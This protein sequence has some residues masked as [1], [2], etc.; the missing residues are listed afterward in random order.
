MGLVRVAQ[1]LLRNRQTMIDR[2]L[3]ILLLGSASI[4]LYTWVG[5]PAFLFLL[6]HLRKY[7]IGKRKIT[8]TVSIIIAAR[9]EEKDIRDRV[10]NLLELD[11]PAD[12]FEILIASDGSIDRTVEIAREFSD[13]RVHVLEFPKQRGRAL[14]HNDVVPLAKGDIIVF[15]DAATRF[16]TSFLSEI[17]SNYA[18][19]RVGCVNGMVDFQNRDAS[20]VTRQRG[21]YWR[22]ELGLRQA[23]SDYGI[24]LCASGQCMS[25]RRNLFRLLQEATYDVDFMTPLDVIDAG[26]LVVQDSTARAT[27]LMFSSSR[28]ELK[29]QARMVSRNLGG[30]LDRRFLVGP[31]RF[32][33][34][35]WSLLSHKVLRWLTPFI[36]LTALLS[37]ILLSIRGHVVSLLLLQ[38]GFY[39]AAAI[40]WWRIELKRPASVFSGPFA[41]CLANVGF[42]LGVMKCIGNERIT[43]Y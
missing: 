27:D 2:A 21:L 6:S 8:P 3:Y 41:F 7:P 29:A 28:Q 39:A 10:Q 40:G 19:P 11:Y 23:E 26:A 42:F 36:L 13:E 12:L 18:D 15:T 34:Y 5:Y 16:E 25:V 33:R 35:A 38:L 30:Y 17:V 4:L 14:V 43:T 32:V 9:N 20:S 22:Y 31:S 37:N 24:L 1:W